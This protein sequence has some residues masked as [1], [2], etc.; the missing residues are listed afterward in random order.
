MT[1]SN[2]SLHSHSLEQL[3]EGLLASKQKVS[4][5]SKRVERTADGLL[6]GDIEN[7]SALYHEIVNDLQAFTSLLGQ[8]Q[9]H[10][11]AKSQ[12]IDLY[13]EQLLAQL[14][15][16]DQIR[17]DQDVHTFAEV[18]QYQMVPFFAGWEGMCRI[19]LQ[20]IP[21]AGPCVSTTKDK[22]QTHYRNEALL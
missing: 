3:K 19:L 4:V 17:Q 12:V 10:L 2:S 21:D 1:K 18:L 16:I 7:S 6:A 5:I 11:E 14:K 8:A 22:G 15:Q 13:H 20:S 9:T